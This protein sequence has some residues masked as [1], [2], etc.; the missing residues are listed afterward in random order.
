MLAQLNII[1]IT[2]AAMI[3]VS[4]TLLSSQVCAE[5][6]VP[7]VIG[8]I[9][10]TASSHP[11]LSAASHPVPIDLAKFGYVEEEFFITGR[12]HVYAYDPAMAPAALAEGPYTNRIIVRRPADQTRF[13]GVA[14][15]DLLNASLL[16]DLSDLWPNAFEYL[17]THGYAYVGMTSK[18]VAIANLKKFD[19]QRYAPLSWASPV[20]GGSRC[21][22]AGFPRLFPGAS[23]PE[24]EDG[25]LWDI[26]SDLGVLLKSTGPQNPLYGKAARE[27]IA[28]GFSQSGSYIGGYARDFQA[29][30][31]TTAGARVYDGFIQGGSTGLSKINQC[32]ELL[33]YGNPHLTMQSRTPFIRMMT[34]TD[35]YDFTPF[36]SYLLRRADSDAEGD[37]FRLYEVAGAAHSSIALWKYNASD[38]EMARVGMPPLQR[39]HCREPVD[40]AFPMGVIWDA[41]LENL[42]Q[43]IRDGRSPPRAARIEVDRPGRPDAVNILDASGNVRGGVRTPAVD[44]PVAS[45]YGKS[46]APEGAADSECRNEGHMVPFSTRKLKQLYPTHANYVNQVERD[47]KKLESER[48][49]TPWDGKRLI[50]RARA[51]RV[52]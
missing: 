11:F 51:A 40:N 45:Y 9:P 36:K 43:W 48:W 24:T 42:L 34:L 1:A 29:H 13:N 12:A 16:V 31:K 30:A 19:S 44:V 2:R 10:V 21:S 49:L 15:V 23:P 26:I 25:L 46:Q 3:W 8:P 7:T 41:A 35:F 39:E 22:Q 5:T 18:P 33:P 38:K 20:V 50:D 32:A 37:K 52:P 14:V 4:L 27:L 17:M 28:V 6:T 47:V